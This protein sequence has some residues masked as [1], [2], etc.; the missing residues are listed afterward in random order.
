MAREIK[1]VG[2]ECLWSHGRKELQDG[3][4]QQGRDHK[5]VKYFK[6]KKQWLDLV[7]Q[8]CLVTKNSSCREAE[9]IDTKLL[10]SEKQVDMVDWPLD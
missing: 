1:E 3:D 9:E 8:K 10:G 7:T 5:W 4:G 2:G 6:G